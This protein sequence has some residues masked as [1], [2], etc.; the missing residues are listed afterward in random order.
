VA[1]AVENP[2]TYAGDT[3][4]K[5]WVPGLGR[6]PGGG[7]GNPLQHS[8][9]EDSKDRGTWWAAVHGAA[10]NWTRLSTLTQ[11]ERKRWRGGT[12]RLELVHIHY[13]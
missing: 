13:Q 4:A 11:E 6:S 2:P 10:K 8:C 3:R 9:Q 1:L 5:G 7:N 12:G